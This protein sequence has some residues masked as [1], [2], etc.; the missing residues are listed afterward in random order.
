[1]A[2]QRCGVSA[3]LKGVRRCRRI[4]S[5][6]DRS[7]LP[8]ARP[9]A[10]TP[11][12]PCGAAAP[13]AAR[14]WRRRRRRASTQ[15]AATRRAPG[16]A[17][18]ARRRRR[19]DGARVGLHDVGQQRGGG[20][21]VGHGVVHLHEEADAAAV[22]GPADGV[23]EVVGEA[24]EHPALPQRP[25]PVELPRRDL[26]DHARPSPAARP[27]PA[28]RPGARGRRGRS[29]GPRSTPGGGGRAAPRRAAGGTA[30]AGG[31]AAPARARSRST[32]NP[33]STP[34]HVEHRVLERVHVQRR[35][36]VVEEAGVEPAQSLHLVRPPSA[37]RHPMHG[38]QTR[39]SVLA[40]RARRGGRRGPAARR[41][42]G[43]WPSTA[44]WSPARPSATCRPA[45]TAATSS[46]RAPR[47]SWRGAIWQLLAEG[48]LAARPTGSPTTSPS[49][50]PTARTTSPSSRCCCTP[51]LPAR[52][53]AARRV[54][55]P[56]RPPRAL[57]H[58]APQL[59]AGHA[60]EY[61]PTSAHW[62]LAEIIERGRRRGLP[63]LRSARVLDPHGLMR[64]ALGVARGRA[65]RR[66]PAGARRRAPDRRGVG[67]RAR[68]RRPRPRRGDRRGARVVQP[69]RA[70]LAVG[71]PGGGAMLD[72]GR[73]G[74]LLPG[75]PPRPEGP[76]GPGR[77]G[78]RH[79]Q[80][81]QH[82][83]RPA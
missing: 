10:R 58:V 53:A 40:A 19:I 20:D 11:A 80:R 71:V 39:S 3:P 17:A 67:G 34:A 30:A 43:R 73:P 24:L 54:G 56:G 42:S 4:G 28:P 55:R 21:A 60:F 1:M 57:R 52:A 15:R 45:T 81:P 13:A 22:G 75:A 70:A 59:G 69:A 5:G 35:R 26:A 46:T 16:R 33:P 6:G 8:A 44:R 78:R 27:A 62:V 32:V 37:C 74:P 76:V 51:R 18:T 48:A 66:R 12:R 63:R 79:R 36:L 25:A 65:G 77:A 9:T 64:L 23:V 29:R 50:G 31:A 82:L 61:H 2:K 83:P 72:G 49:S 7:R 47:P 68:R 14:S 41:A 38:R